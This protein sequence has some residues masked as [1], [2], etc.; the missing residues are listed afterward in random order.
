MIIVFSRSSSSS[1]SCSCSRGDSRHDDDSRKIA[2]TLATVIIDE[3]GRRT[4][5]GSTK[6]AAATS[7]P[8][9]IQ[10]VTR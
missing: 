1:S 6:I 10:G 2:T 7:A 8:G 9:R 4:E 5:K 3:N